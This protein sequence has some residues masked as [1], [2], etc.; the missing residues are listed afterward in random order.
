MAASKRPAHAVI[1]GYTQKSMHDRIEAFFLDNVGRIASRGQIIKEAT[2]PR[3]GKFP[4]TGT[5]AHPNCGRTTDTQ[6]SRSKTA[7]I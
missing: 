1:R 7:G 4:K 3:T 2:D 6:Y 5:N